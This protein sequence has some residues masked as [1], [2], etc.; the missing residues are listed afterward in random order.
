MKDEYTIIPPSE[1]FF[2]SSHK[3]KWFSNE[4]YYSSLNI[5]N[6]KPKIAPIS[7]EDCR[8]VL[9]DKVPNIALL[10][11][12]RLNSKF[13]I[14]KNI[15]VI[16]NNDIGLFALEA[17]K[18]GAKH[19]YSIEP[20]KSFSIYQAQI[21]KDNN[22]NE[23]ITLIN[24]DIFDVTSNDIDIQVD[25]VVCNWPGYFLIQRSLVNEVIYARD[26]FLKPKGHIF[27][28]CGKIYIA[29]IENVNFKLNTLNMWDNIYDINMSC[30]KQ[31]S[32]SDPM[33]Q[34]V[35]KGRIISSKCL[36]YSIDMYTVTEEDLNF[37]NEYL[38]TIEK[39]D[40]LSGLITWFDIKFNK[41]P[42]KIVYSTS[43]YSGST[44]WKQI[45]FYLDKDIRV[46]KGDVVFGSIASR[47]NEDLQD[48]D[49]LDIKISYHVTRGKEK[50][51]NGVRL[52]KLK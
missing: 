23:K 45:S 14:N 31:E 35:D 32:I 36:I 22:L 34:C 41:T 44:K 17:A 46:D 20:N 9:D 1:T 15:L 30:I 48:M 28:D 24:K 5:P 40:D 13:F 11:A 42:N 49:G 12:M 51:N 29:G 47:I 39:D 43:P 19:V 18:I 25:V 3:K 38:I 10:S 27:P 21:I 37:S 7:P 52:Y 2:Q 16:C 8:E 50:I 6:L 4:E 26:T 33:I